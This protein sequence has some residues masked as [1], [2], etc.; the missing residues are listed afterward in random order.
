MNVMKNFVQITDIILYSVVAVAGVVFI[1][2]SFSARKRNKNFNTKD[3]KKLLRS[4]FKLFNDINKDYTLDDPNSTRADTIDNKYIKI[5]NFCEKVQCQSR[6]IQKYEKT[7]H[8]IPN[9]K[10]E[11]FFQILNSVSKNMVIQKKVIT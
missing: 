10:D 1:A 4:F 7:E 9:R 11:I 6:K 8:K 3:K 5:K 2:K